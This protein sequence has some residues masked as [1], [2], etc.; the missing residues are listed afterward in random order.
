MDLFRA[1]HHIVDANGGRVF[2]F[3]CMYKCNQCQFACLGTDG[4]MLHSLPTYAS[5]QYPVDACCSTA[6]KIQ[7]HQSLTQMYNVL[8]ITHLPAD[9]MAAWMREA[10]YK[11][12]VADSAEYFSM[13]IANGGE[14][15]YVSYDEWSHGASMPAPKSLLDAF[16]S[17]FQSTFTL[18]GISE[19]DRCNR[20][21]QS[22]GCESTFS[23]DHHF[24]L[25]K[26]YSSVERQQAK[27]VLTVMVETGEVACVALVP[28]TKKRMP[29]MHWSSLLG[30]PTS[31]PRAT[32]VTFIPPTETS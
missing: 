10:H 4:A 30:D 32:G 19:M 2:A 25:V 5:A 16:R 26:N 6:T 20:E 18:S 7:L 28:T 12:Y 14:P 29:H 1:S 27:A 8:G 23:F 9:P 17:G 11:M 15:D 24:A 3:T 31:S 22:V 13:V 21:M